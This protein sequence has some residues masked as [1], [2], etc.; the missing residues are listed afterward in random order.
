MIE[1]VIAAIFAALLILEGLL[2]AIMPKQTLK[3]VKK[4][5]KNQKKLWTIGIIEAIIG[6]VLLFLV[7]YY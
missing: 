7:L 1:E 6:V 3:L 4:F 5:L 2:V